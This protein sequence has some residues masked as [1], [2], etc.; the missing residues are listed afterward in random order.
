MTAVPLGPVVPDAVCPLPGLERHVGRAVTLEPLSAR[1]VTDLWA[2][3]EAADISWAYLRYGPFATEQELAAHIERIGGLDRQPFFAV[4]PTTSGRAEGWASFCDIAPGDAA[5]EI[6]SIWFSPRLQRTRAATEAIFLMMRHAFALG[7]H[8]VVWRCNALNAASMRAARRFG[9]T[10]EGTWRGDGIVK[11]R[12][13]DTA[14]FS[15]LDDEWP[16]QRMLFEAWLDDR[17]FEANGVALMSLSPL[18]FDGEMGHRRG[19]Q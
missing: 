2:A 17:N 9:F 6:G 12:R 18:V 14:W 13:R 1:H 16:D 11:G 15:I 3:G 10:Y 8:R 7:Y 4:I 19:Q 5:I